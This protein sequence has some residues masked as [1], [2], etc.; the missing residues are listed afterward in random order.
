MNPLL[1]KGMIVLKGQW[2][3]LGAVRQPNGHRYTHYYMTY[4]GGP[5]NCLL[6]A[7][8]MDTIMKLGVKVNEHWSKSVR[9]NKDLKSVQGFRFHL[10]PEY[11]YDMIQV[12]PVVQ[13]LVAGGDND[14]FLGLLKPTDPDFY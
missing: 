14:L 1:K 13:S 4:S 10:V 11:E 7:Q 5:K 8:D 2:D 12:D 3:G 6:I 9:Q